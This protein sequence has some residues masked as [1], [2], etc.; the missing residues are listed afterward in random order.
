LRENFTDS[1]I[2]SLRYARNSRPIKIILFQNVL[3][4]QR[5]MP[6]QRARRNL[7]KARPSIMD[8]GI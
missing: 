7:S 8:S 5:D 2:T 1:F 3:F 4:T 6:C